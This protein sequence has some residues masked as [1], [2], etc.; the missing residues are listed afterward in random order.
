MKKKRRQTKITVPQVWMMNI[1]LGYTAEQMRPHMTRAALE[2]FLSRRERGYFSN[3]PK[4]K[5]V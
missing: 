2:L 5:V 1:D 3:S 4:A